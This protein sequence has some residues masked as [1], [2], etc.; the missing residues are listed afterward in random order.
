MTAKAFF[1][2]LQFFK[3]RS[4]RGLE[5]PVLLIVDGHSSHKNLS[6]IKFAK[7]NNIHMISLPP[8]TT[9]KLQPLDRTYMEPLKAKYNECAAKFV[10]EC[11]GCKIL[12]RDVPHL[13]ITTL[14][15]FNAKALLLKSFQ[16]TGI[17]PLN[18]DIFTERDY[19]PSREVPQTAGREVTEVLRAIMPPPTKKKKSNF[20]NYK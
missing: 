9:H 18:R 5:K 2:W 11:G 3:L 19:A 12:E 13:I 14:E 10:R 1:E 17:Y 16:C 8:H 6:N 15:Q 4:R 20:K 7:T